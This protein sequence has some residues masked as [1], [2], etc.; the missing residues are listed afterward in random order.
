MGEGTS[1][2]LLA[3]L[4]MRWGGLG[5]YQYSGGYGI[6]CYRSARLLIASNLARL[7]GCAQVPQ[8]L[9][10]IVVLPQSCDL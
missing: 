4:P 8:A 7:T 10:S 6:H 1:A 9:P 3:P 2:E 5:L